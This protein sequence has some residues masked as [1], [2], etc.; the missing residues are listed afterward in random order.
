M[1][2]SVVSRSLGHTDVRMTARYA[3]IVDPTRQLVSATTVAVVDIG[4]GVA[5][6]DLRARTSRYVPGPLT[7]QHAGVSS[8][9]EVSI[10]PDGTTVYYAT[11]AGLEAM[12]LHTGRVTILTKRTTSPPS[13]QLERHCS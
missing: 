9:Q 5:L 6:V 10:S 11:T 3:H 12:D 4:G 13:R 7:R 2:D 1:A 8:A